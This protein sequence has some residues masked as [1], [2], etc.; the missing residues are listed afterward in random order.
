MDQK[1]IRT[2]V[3]DRFTRHMGFC[4]QFLAEK[5]LAEHIGDY[6][7]MTYCI[8]RSKHLNLQYGEVPEWDKIAELRSS[9]LRIG[10][11]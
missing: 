2:I 7:R 9:F 3:Q 1:T 6:A 8:L 4:R 11:A 10:F 5:A